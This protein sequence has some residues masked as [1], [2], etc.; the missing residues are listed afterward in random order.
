[1]PDLFLSVV[2]FIS[3]GL[4]A[5]LAYVRLRAPDVAMAEAAIG[6][7][8]TGALLLSALR[9]LGI[10]V[11]VSRQA[12]YRVLTGLALLLSAGLGWVVLAQPG[13]SDG[14]AR[15]ASAQLWQSGV[16][17]PVTAVLLNFRAYD[18]LLEVAVLLLAVVGVWVVSSTELGLPAAATVL[19]GMVS[20]LVPPGLLVA[21]YIVW[22]GAYQPG[23]AFQ[24]G[25]VL[26]G[27]L[28]LLLLTGWRMQGAAWPLRLA[29]GAG[30]LSF[31]AVGMLAMVGGSLLEYRLETAKRLILLIEFALTVSVAATLAILLLGRPPGSTGSPSP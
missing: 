15:Q 28:V 22:V 11:E 10:S 19:R 17:H 14:L 6:A 25:A 8:L 29:L 4:L 23:G 21:G 12:P 2:L 3:F 26:G 5:S 13:H 1:T 16:E 27:L 9:Q 31:L 7:A 30:L 24:R 20:L 18:T